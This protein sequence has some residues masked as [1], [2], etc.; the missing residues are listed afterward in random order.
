MRPGLQR[1]AATLFGPCQKWQAEE[2][3][4]KRE[5]PLEMVDFKRQPG[6]IDDR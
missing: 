6:E 4:I 5:G 3:L 2:G 1:D